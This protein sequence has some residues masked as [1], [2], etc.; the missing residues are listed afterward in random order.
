MAQQSKKAMAD[1]SE[2]GAGD[3][4]E[5][6]R[7][8]PY[9]K[10][11]GLMLRFLYLMAPRQF[12]KMPTPF[13]VIVTRAPK[14]M[15]IFSTLGKY[16]GKGVRLEKEL[17]YQILMFVAETNGCGFCTDFGRLM[18][19]K[20]NMPTEKF[21]AL[22]EYKTSPLFSERERAALAYAEEVTRTKRASDETFEALRKHFADWEIVEIATL[23]AIQN[24]ENMLFM[25]LGIGSDG[26]CAIAQARKK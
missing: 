8:K 17:H 19:M 23:T 6:L 21:S 1:Q 5:T 26:L 13:R 11:S 25:P 22:L 2:H 4:S 14:T 7:L 10:P 12:G 24:F 15:G 18:V 16:E 9:D 3:Y 20:A